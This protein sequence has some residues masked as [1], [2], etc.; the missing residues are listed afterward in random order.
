MRRSLTT[1]EGCVFEKK[2]GDR[3]KKKGLEEGQWA[4]ESCPWLENKP[5][6]NNILAVFTV[7]QAHTA[8][9]LCAQTK[10]QLPSPWGRGPSNT[11]VAL[12]N[13]AQHGEVGLE[14]TWQFPAAYPPSYSSL[15]HHYNHRPPPVPRPHIWIT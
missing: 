15:H 14:T 6:I 11:D 3:E 4:T 13:W 2:V 8:P 5:I 12:I 1:Q 7:K 10:T 9:N